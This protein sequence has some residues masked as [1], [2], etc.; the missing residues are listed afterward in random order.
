MIYRRIRYSN[1]VTKLCMHYT[2]R[3]YTFH[4]K[5][6]AQ[7]GNTRYIYSVFDL[8]AYP[9]GREDI[10]H[11]VYTWRRSSA[12]FGT[13]IKAGYPI[14]GDLLETIAHH[15][16]EGYLVYIPTAPL[17]IEAR[18]CQWD[19]HQDTV[20]Y[21]LASQEVLLPDD[22]HGILSRHTVRD[23]PP[24]PPGLCQLLNPIVL[25]VLNNSLFNERESKMAQRYLCGQGLVRQVTSK[26]YDTVLVYAVTKK[27]G[28]LETARFYTSRIQPESEA[29]Q[30][31]LAGNF[32]EAYTHSYTD[33]ALHLLEY[34]TDRIRLASL[35]EYAP[36]THFFKC[37]A[38]RFSYTTEEYEDA[39]SV[40]AGN[41]NFFSIPVLLEKCTPDKLTGKKY[42][43]V[44]CIQDNDRLTR[45][46]FYLREELVR[47]KSRF[48]Y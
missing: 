11:K 21:L 47:I 37:I 36:S 1:T 23:I 26:I 8:Y 10:L 4:M 27:G 14:E 28:C 19:I 33:V 5:I 44:K 39:L 6:A 35:A 22:I 48:H 15:S 45:E 2:G 30:K 40:A 16:S 20:K 41:C 29:Q 12:L 32:V 7:C 9:F 43:L 46:N 18:G 34:I 3:E 13:L 17:L 42:N 25:D 24:G 31:I 38:D